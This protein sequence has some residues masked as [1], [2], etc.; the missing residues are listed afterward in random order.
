MS[1]GDYAPH[2][3]RPHGRIPLPAGGHGARLTSVN[4]SKEDASSVIVR[5]I[6]WGTT[7]AQESGAV[8]RARLATAEA[9]LRPCPAEALRTGYCLLLRP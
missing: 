3:S 4:L 8:E 6:I 1:C 9:L 2:G 7:E 5:N